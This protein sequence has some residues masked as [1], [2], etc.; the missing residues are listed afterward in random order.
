M[1]AA[2]DLD[3]A[4]LRFTHCVLRD[5]IHDQNQPIPE[6]GIVDD[7]K[8]QQLSAKLG[9]VVSVSESGFE[10]EKIG[11]FATE[12]VMERWNDQMSA[13]EMMMRSREQ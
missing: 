7:E 1:L 3:A 10:G 12:E 4:A 2:P 9:D 5:C 6:S 11:V 13:I 8:C